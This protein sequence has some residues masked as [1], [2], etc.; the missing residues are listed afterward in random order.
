M[1]S[2]RV[3]HDWATNKKKTQATNIRN[4]KGN[5]TTDT[6]VI[7]RIIK[8]YYAQIK[9]LRRNGQVLQKSKAT[10]WSQDEVENPDNA[11]IEFVIKTLSKI[12]I[13]PGQDSFPK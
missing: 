4:E 12:I 13:T 7:K 2:Q 10:K 3:G 8:E 5:V 1:G 6:V 9:K 11:K